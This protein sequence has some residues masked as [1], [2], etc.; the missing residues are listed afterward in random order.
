MKINTVLGQIDSKDL[1]VTLMHEHIHTLSYDFAVAFP[2]HFNKEK[3]VE[4]FCE[5]MKPLKEKYG[6]KTFVDATPITLGRNVDLMKECAEKAEV[7]IIAVTGLYWQESPS[8]L[9]GVDPEYLADLFIGEIEHGMQ[10]T[11][12]KPGIIKAST[13]KANNSSETNR[14]MVKAAAIAHKATGLP[15]YTHSDPT[16][17]TA[18]FQKEVFE[19]MGVD[20][21]HVAYG[22]AGSCGNQEY[23]KKLMEPGSYV[24]FDQ[25]GFFLP[26]WA[27]DSFN[28]LKTFM[29]DDNYRKQLFLSCDQA[30]F[31]D[32]GNVGQPWL[33]DK[34]KN[35]CCITEARRRA[36]FEYSVDW[37]KAQGVT[38]AQI[39]EVF[40][41]N[42]RRFFGEEI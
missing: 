12:I 35:P 17:E 11:G 32:Y 18:L 1:G 37:L 6:L 19:E 42:P 23:E 22:H 2:G 10:G 8:F 21:K 4:L 16:G 36:L 33:R 26:D 20:M 3:T 9:D 40:T 28:A 13:Q 39:D 25:I 38:Q 34:E 15:I 14:N 31:S 5:E 7:N 27:P 29:Q 41:L 30:V 24:G